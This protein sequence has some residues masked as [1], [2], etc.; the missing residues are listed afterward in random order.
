MNYKHYTYYIASEFQWR[1]KLNQETGIR[2]ISEF[3]QLHK[4]QG[5]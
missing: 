4:L 3:H 1:I 5:I 2:K